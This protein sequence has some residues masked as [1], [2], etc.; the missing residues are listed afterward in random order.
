MGH[1]FPVMRWAKS[2][3]IVDHQLLHRGFFQKLSHQALALYL[4]LVVVGDAQ[5]RSYY[6]DRTI[7][8]ILRLSD[9]DLSVA[10][11]KLIEAGLINYRGPYWWV[12]NLGCASPQDKQDKKNT[13]RAV[14]S[15]P[16]IIGDI[17]RGTASQAKE[18]THA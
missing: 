5:G 15:V 9:S 1:R 3:S 10:R 8:G 16:T 7:Q 17:L 6:A 18:R 2:Y 14:C 13:E 12:R 4:F 11:D